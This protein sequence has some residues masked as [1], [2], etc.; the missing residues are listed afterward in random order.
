MSLRMVVFRIANMDV[1]S[2]DTDYG[3]IWTSCQ[4][5]TVRNV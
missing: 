3:G 1:I 2:G 4:L 5:S